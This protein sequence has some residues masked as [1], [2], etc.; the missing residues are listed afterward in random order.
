MIARRTAEIGFAATTGLFG[1]VIAWGAREFGVGWTPSGPEP[2]AFPFAIGCVI[3]VASLGNALA[4]LRAEGDDASPLLSGDQFK[5]ILA[6]V[7]PIL[8]FVAL[9]LWLGLYVAMALYLFATIRF[10]GRYSTLNAA[11]I[12]VGAPIGLYLLLEMAFQTPLLKGPLEAALG[13]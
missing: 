13:L 4:A 10:Q 7:A 12:A 5:R 11:L 9:S 6:F 8:V 1:L 2:G 3:A